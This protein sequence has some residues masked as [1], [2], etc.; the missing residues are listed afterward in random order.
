MSP[1]KAIYL[2][3]NGNQKL[4]SGCSAV[5]PHIISYTIVAIT[6]S[7]FYIYVFSDVDKKIQAQKRHNYIYMTLG[8]NFKEATF[9]KTGLYIYKCQGFEDTLSKDR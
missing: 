9:L 1:L 5:R 6:F 8:F 7:F 3:K 4:N 2:F